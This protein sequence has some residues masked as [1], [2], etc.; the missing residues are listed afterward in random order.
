MRKVFFNGDFVD[1]SG[2]VIGKHKGIIYYTIGQRKGLNLP[3]TSPYYVTDINPLNN[4]VYL[5]HGENL[6]RTELKANNINLISVPKIEGELRCNAKIRYRSKE[7]PCTV[8]QS[9][10]DELTVRFDEGQR[11]ITKGQ[12]VVLYDGDIVV[13][14]GTII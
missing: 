13:G 9:G 2:R 7:A 5:S 1:E 8:I 14:G 10:D 11:A 12:S 6:F 3:S 4:R